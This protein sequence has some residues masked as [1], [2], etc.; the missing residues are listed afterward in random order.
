MQ[1]VSI[2]PMWFD[3]FYVSLLSERYKKSGV[4]GMI[5]AVMIGCISN[6]IALRNNRKASSI[7]YEI[8]KIE[9]NQF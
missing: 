7:V 2:N 6:L 8:K 1:I 9:T 3:S 5:R 4:L